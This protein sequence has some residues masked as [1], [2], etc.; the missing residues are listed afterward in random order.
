ML[1]VELCERGII[2]D[3]LQEKAG[4]SGLTREKLKRKFYIEIFYGRNQIVTDFT[5]LFERTFPSVMEMIRKVKRPD[6]TV[7]ACE[8]QRRESR[9]VIHGVCR[10]LMEEYPHVPI[11]TI[12]DSILTTAE[13]AQ[14][15]RDAML[16]E[17]A[18]IGM[19]PTL[20]VEDFGRQV[21]G[22]AA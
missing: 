12:H 18:L 19:T 7:L 1:Y 14:T 4:L 22:M 20:K 8:M 5:R 21:A 6:H 16:R 9:I 17:F 2:Y 13:H 11:I 15:V 10:R 3:Y